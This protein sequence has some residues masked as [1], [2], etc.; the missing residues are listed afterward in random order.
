MNRDAADQVVQSTGVLAMAYYPEIHAD[1]ADYSIGDDVD[2]VLSDAGELEPADIAALRDLVARTIIDPTN[3][4]E[5]LIEYV[6]GLVPDGGEN[7]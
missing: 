6:F 1:D 3:H 2:F 5:A 4:R 7:S